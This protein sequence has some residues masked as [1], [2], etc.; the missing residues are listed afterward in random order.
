MVSA[1]DKKLAELAEIIQETATELSVLVASGGL[2]ETLKWG[3]RSFLP[4]KG[5]VG[6]TVRIAQASDTEVA[7]YVHCQTTLVDTYRSLF[8]ELAYEG[9][10]AVLFAVDEPLPRESIPIC[11]TE[12]LLYHYNKKQRAKAV[13]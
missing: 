9:N 11:V 13:I 7:M 2:Q 6:T 10:R 5:G 3:Q 1:A 4:K 12:A 8:P